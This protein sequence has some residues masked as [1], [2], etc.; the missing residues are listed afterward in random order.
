[1]PKSYRILISFLVL[2]LGLFIYLEN[3]RP[4]KPDWTPTFSSQD[5]IPL[6]SFIFYENLEN[7]DLAVAQVPQTPYEFLQDTTLQGTYFFLNPA[8]EMSP[9]GYKALLDWVKK[10]N[11]VFIASYDSPFF[12]SDSLSLKIKRKQSIK[13]IRDYPEF[14][15]TD[16]EFKSDSAYV[17]KHNTSIAYFSQLDSAKTKVLGKVGLETDSTDFNAEPNYVE[18][19][20]GKGKFFLH[21][22]PEVFSNAFLLSENNYHYTERA[23]AYLDKENPVYF[24]LSFDQKYQYGQTSPLYVLFSNRYLKWGYYFLLIGGLLFVIFEGKRKQKAIKVI[25]PLRNSTYDYTRTIAGMYL[26]TGDHGS[27]AAKKIAQF[28]NYIRKEFNIP[29]VSFDRGL[30]DKLGEQTENSEEDIEDLFKLINH[31]QESQ[32]ISEKELITLNQK[33]INF[34]ENS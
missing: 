22:S 34:K 13:S 6:G 3:A 17:F 27:M 12:S 8:M 29:D 33:I 19:S 20:Y 31:I 2:L 10:G 9:S 1:M 14:N 16:P 28:Q 15:L 23:M 32:S 24:D 7:K 21:T 25:P 26:E 4:E 5:K 30:A 18:V 11:R